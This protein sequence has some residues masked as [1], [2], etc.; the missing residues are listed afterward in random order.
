MLMRNAFCRGVG[1]TNSRAANWSPQSR[2]QSFSRAF[3]S[4]TDVPDLS[5][6]QPKL[7]TSAW[8][9]GRLTIQAGMTSLFF[10]CLFYG[11]YR[12]L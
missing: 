11:I 4:L 12:D 1:L 10:V 8:A 2:V 3:P 6:N 7:C 9:K 5:L